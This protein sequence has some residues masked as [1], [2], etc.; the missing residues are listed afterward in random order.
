MHR[1]KRFF[2]KNLRDL[3]ELDTYIGGWRCAVDLNERPF[4]QTVLIC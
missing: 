4:M 2:L 3:V 1:R